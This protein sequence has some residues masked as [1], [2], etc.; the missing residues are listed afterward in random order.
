MCQLYHTVWAMNVPNITPRVIQHKS[1]LTHLT[2]K[3]LKV[4]KITNTKH[5]GI[6][7]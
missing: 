4:N 2:S 5:V 6:K 1:R 7:H 3:V